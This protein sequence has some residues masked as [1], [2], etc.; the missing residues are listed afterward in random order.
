VSSLNVL[1]L[2]Y[3]ENAHGPGK[4]ESF[5]ASSAGVEK[6]DSVQG[7]AKRDMAVAEHH[8]V[9]PGLFYS[10]QNLRKDL[11]FFQRSV[12]KKKFFPCKDYESVLRQ[13]RRRKIDIS[14]DR[15]YGCDGFE[16]SQHGGAADIA[17]MQ[18]AIDLR[19]EI[20]DTGMEKT[21]SVGNDA[22]SHS[23]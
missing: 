23:L 7:S 18:D 6:K 19:K 21:M 15:V 5:P 14:R 11:V 9:W 3:S 22:Y 16:L 1:F 4:S 10:P 20:K 13:Y 8:R 17:G 2:L 12:A